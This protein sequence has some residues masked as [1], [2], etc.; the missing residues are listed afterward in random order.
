MTII[1]FTYG[2]LI[3]SFLN[4]CIYR[5]P[6][7]ESIVFPSSY[8]LSCKT[9]L[10]WYD[11]IPVL[12]YIKIKGRCRYCKKK[13]SLQYP[14]IELLNA[15]I[16]LLLF[17][18]FNLSIDFIFYA[19]ISSTLIL[20]TIIDLKEMM[21]PDSLVITIAILSILHKSL[22]YIIHK[23]PTNLLDSIEG[24]LLAGIIF[25]LIVIISKGGMGGG[26]VTLI[27]AL[28]FILGVKHILLAIFLSFILGGVIS[29]FLL[30]TKLKTK[31][32][33]VPFGPFIV[34]GFIITSFWGE[35]LIEWY[36]SN[37]PNI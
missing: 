21:I 26:D 24:A 28:G 4:V 12:S 23:T 16:Y 27:I 3:G 25:L 5:I 32:D 29:A 19:L 30:I 13:I 8:C 35:C 31:K 2:M 33:P 22:N 10:K 9:N 37:F 36:L 1:I 6:R 20:I 34:L 17:H 14:M 18:R 7:Q 15:I 11:N